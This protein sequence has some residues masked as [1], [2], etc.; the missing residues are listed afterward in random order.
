[1]LT[2]FWKLLLLISMASLSLSDTLPSQSW[3]LAEGMVSQDAVTSSPD[4]AEM[5]K[6]LSREI[7]TSYKIQ[8]T[9]SYNIHSKIL[10]HHLT[11]KQHHTP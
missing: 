10:P 6:S 5:T 7:M 9:T 2:Q 11:G 4:S 1:M 8:K 3:Q